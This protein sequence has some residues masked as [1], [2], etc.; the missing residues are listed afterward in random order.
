MTRKYL[1]ILNNSR[2]KDVMEW[3]LAQLVDIK[4]NKS[5]SKSRLGNMAGRLLWFRLFSVTPESALR[6]TSN[7]KNKGAWKWPTGKLLQ[8]VSLIFFVSLLGKPQPFIPHLGWTVVLWVVF[9]LFMYS[10][11][12]RSLG[13]VWRCMFRYGIGIRFPSGSRKKCGS[14]S[15]LSV[16]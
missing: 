4:I 7:I 15:F 1:H 2:K 14:I 6:A 13:P 11:Y 8:Y 10:A 3:I 9:S 16:V 12:V 5:V